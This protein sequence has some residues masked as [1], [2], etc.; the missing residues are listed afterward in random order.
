ML[1]NATTVLSICCFCLSPACVLNTFP[2]RNHL[3]CPHAVCI[4]GT[5]KFFVEPTIHVDTNR[6]L[7]LPSNY[8]NVGDYTITVEYPGVIPPPD[9]NPLT[10]CNPRSICSSGCSCST[11]TSGAPTCSCNAA[12]GLKRGT[13]AGKPACI[14][15][16][17]QPT[18]GVAPKW[19][20]P[21]NIGFFA[22]PARGLVKIPWLSTGCPAAGKSVVSSAVLLSATACPTPAAATAAPL[23]LAGTSE[24]VN[25]ENCTVSSAV[26]GRR[27]GYRVMR[28]VLAGGAAPVVGTCYGFRVAT[29]DGRAYNGVMQVTARR[30]SSSELP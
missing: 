21:S 19:S 12:Q 29:T 20:V 16:L 27:A 25:T 30:L 15:N 8:G 6:T 14:W 3:L 7:D 4:A 28:V 13:L 11:T 26:P 17:L 18:T 9:C 23:D 10:T 24:T 22:A 1:T 2:W 5:Y